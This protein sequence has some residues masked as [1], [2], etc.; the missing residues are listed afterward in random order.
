VDTD[1][2]SEEQVLHMNQKPPAITKQLYLKKSPNNNVDTTNTDE[3][4]QDSDAA[5]TTPPKHTIIDI[6]NTT[7]SDSNDEQYHGPDPSPGTN[8]NKPFLIL[9]GSRDSKKGNPVAATCHNTLWKE[10]AT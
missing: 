6:S 8:N 3:D 4:T 5:Y 7:D 10:R 9:H 1:D 2:L